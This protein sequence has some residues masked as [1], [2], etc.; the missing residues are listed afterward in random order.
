[1]QGI[2]KGVAGDVGVLRQHHEYRVVIAMVDKYMGPH[3]AQCNGVAA[4]R[5]A[6]ANGADLGAVGA[7]H[8]RGAQHF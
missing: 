6:E 5:G 2:T 1:V 8:R 4:L 7:P 3:F